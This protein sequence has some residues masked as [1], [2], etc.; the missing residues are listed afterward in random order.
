MLKLNETFIPQLAAVFLSLTLLTAC[1]STNSDA[2]SGN[3][4]SSDGPATASA[5]PAIESATGP[6]PT[7]YV[8]STSR[9]GKTDEIPDSLG[10]GSSYNT[11]F[12]FLEMDHRNVG[13]IDV[14][15]IEGSIR[16]INSF[17]DEA[18]RLNFIE[19]ATIQPGR[20]LI[21]KDGGISFKRYECDMSFQ[22]WCRAFDANFANYSIDVIIDRVALANGDVIRG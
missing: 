10:L 3:A 21:D 15:G 5:E 18:A 17:G 9:V 7:D 20:N 22:D 2:P 19:T 1:S 13:S 8:T 6:Q 16:L 12:I 4:N 14:V 11:I